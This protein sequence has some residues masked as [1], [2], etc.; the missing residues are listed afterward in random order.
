MALLLNGC[1]RRRLCCRNPPVAARVSSF[2]YYL[3]DLL[4]AEIAG[5]RRQAT[6]PMRT[7]R[8]GSGSPGPSGSL[9]NAAPAA[10]QPPPLP[11]AA[12][13]A[14]AVGA[15]TTSGEHHEEST[16]ATAG[17]GAG[18]G[19]GYRWGRYLGGGGQHHDARSLRN[20]RRLGDLFDHCRVSG[21]LLAGLLGLLRTRNFSDLGVFTRAVLR[22]WHARRYRRFL[23]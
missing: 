4:P 8:S 11:A 15:T 6:S 2:F 17:V 23:G 3:Q 7:P 21:Q 13:A 1:Q 22:R 5:S 18:G 19:P 14:A 10:A 16:T 9:T 12:A 20:G